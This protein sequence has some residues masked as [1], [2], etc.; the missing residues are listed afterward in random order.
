MKDWPLNLRESMLMER[1]CSHG[2][3]H[4]DPDSLAWMERNGREGYGVHGCDGCC[5]GK[6][7]AT[8]ADVEAA[9]AAVVKEPVPFEK[10][11]ANCSMREGTML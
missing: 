11:C 4:P 9:A 3:G 10:L 2:I 1:I 6:R 7:Y 5:S 8:Q